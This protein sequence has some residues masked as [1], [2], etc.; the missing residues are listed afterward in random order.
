MD[1][2]QRD[3]VQQYLRQVLGGSEVHL[4]TEKPKLHELRR[5]FETSG[6]P[7]CL[8]IDWSADR[9]LVD[10]VSYLS[11]IT[12]NKVGEA[13]ILSIVSTHLHGLAKAAGALP[14]ISDHNSQPLWQAVDGLVA[15]APGKWLL[16]VP[17]VGLQMN[18]GH[19]SLLGATYCAPDLESLSRA[20][21]ANGFEPKA[22]LE[23][24]QQT[25]QQYAG[26]FSFSGF[27]IVLGV[28]DSSAVTASA[29]E[30]VRNAAYAANAL[31]YFCGLMPP[32]RLALPDDDY[33]GVLP[34]FGQ[35][36]TGGGIWSWGSRGRE[37]GGRVYGLPLSKPDVQEQLTAHPAST[38]LTTCFSEFYEGRASE[39]RVNLCAMWSMLGRAVSSRSRLD[40]LVYSVISMETAFGLNAKFNL[41]A[42]VSSFGGALVSSSRSDYEANKKRIGSLYDER[43]TFVHAGRGAISK[44]RQDMALDFAHRIA[45][46]LVPLAMNCADRQSL[47]NTLRERVVALGGDDSKLGE[48]LRLQES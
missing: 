41:R 36:D 10:L 34:T 39:P 32:C 16:C 4:R 22:I 47:H 3:K 44:A 21:S 43:S 31:L 18:T 9:A 13:K 30:I 28:G 29:E 20:T 24:L 8:S 12:A 6:N 38:N 45:K 17:I 40:S 46:E 1:A 25:L 2:N 48:V 5:T 14:Q 11:K 15:S 42:C 35:S 33:A 23:G 37:M 27:G 26:R 19:A 7:I